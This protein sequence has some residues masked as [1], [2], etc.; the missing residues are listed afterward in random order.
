M[1]SSLAEPVVRVLISAIVLSLFVLARRHFPAK[2]GQE[3]N[4]D[5][6]ARLNHRFK[7]TQW[8]IGA[9][10]LFIAIAAGWTGYAFLTGLNRLFAALDGP[11]AFVL[12]PQT[13]IWWFLPGFT[14][15]ILTWEITVG[16]FAWVGGKKNAELYRY[17]SEAKTGIDATRILR[18]IALAVVLP[19]GILTA[20]ALPEHD[21]LQ[22]TG[23]LSRGYAFGKTTYS[24]KDAIRMTTIEGFRKRDGGLTRRAGIVLGFF[25]REP[26]VF[27]G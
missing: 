6:I 23:I 12:L 2:I 24:Y 8:R 7:R 13:A 22:N 16:A 25:G 9:S 14:G 21:L 26:L 15:L 11:S 17:W 10:M 27:G 18:L 1:A 5:S 4:A 20:L 19:I 3:E